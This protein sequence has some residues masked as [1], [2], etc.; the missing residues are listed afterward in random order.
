MVNV[1][2]VCIQHTARISHTCYLL[3]LYF[4]INTPSSKAV[5]A[6]AQW[7]IGRYAIHSDTLSKL[8][9]RH[10]QHLCFPRAEVPRIRLGPSTPQHKSKIYQA[11]LLLYINRILQ[12]TQGAL[13]KNLLSFQGRSLASLRSHA[14][15]RNVTSRATC[16]VCYRGFGSCSCYSRNMFDSSATD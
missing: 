11:Y 15:Q 2:E 5:R 3:N 7:G 9:P 13:N 10:L 1:D 6:Q 4:Q 12:P 14:N 16:G 8:L